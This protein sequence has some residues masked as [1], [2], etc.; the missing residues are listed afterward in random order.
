MG[1]AGLRVVAE[2]FDSIACRIVSFWVCF[3]A[4]CISGK[5]TFMTEAAGAQFTDAFNGMG[6][7]LLPLVIAGTGILSSIIGTFF[8]KISNNDAKEA[9]VQLDQSGN[10]F[11]A[12]VVE[13]ER[14]HALGSKLRAN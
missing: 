2:R 4:R 8:V 13:L 7:I 12:V 3:F 10:R 9:Q 5:Q 11:D 14:A 1:G 6:P